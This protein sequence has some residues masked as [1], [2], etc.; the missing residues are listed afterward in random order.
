MNRMTL[1][2]VCTRV[3]IFLCEPMTHS[4]IKII[5]L[6]VC[7]CVYES[8]LLC[9]RTV[10]V[11]HRGEFFGHLSPAVCLCQRPT[12]F[13]YL[14]LINPVQG[15]S[16]WWLSRSRCD[17]WTF[18]AIGFLM[19]LAVFS[20]RGHTPGLLPPAYWIPINNVKTV[21]FSVDVLYCTT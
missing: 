7:V 19:F 6:C 12:L 16:Y 2:G 4:C 3:F 10:C 11:C 15:N 14:L 9:A 18:W 20:L 13:S 1:C 5:C 17:K 8:A 21:A